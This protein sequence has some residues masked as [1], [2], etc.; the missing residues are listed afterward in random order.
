MILSS[1]R[2]AEI[3]CGGTLVVARELLGC[4]GVIQGDLCVEKGRILGCDLEVAG[5]VLVSE[6]GSREEVRTRLHLGEAIADDQNLLRLQRAHSKAED[7]LRQF[8]RGRGRLLLQPGADGT[9]PERFE[10]LQRRQSALQAV[11]RRARR[12]E[13]VLR[14]RMESRRLSCSLTINAVVHAGVEVSFSGCPTRYRFTEEMTGPLRV[15]LAEGAQ[16]ITVTSL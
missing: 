9:H 5:L 16:E 2:E 14:K 15:G 3:A 13:F 6:L 11:A 12:R 10:S 4:H 1:A 8:H 7:A